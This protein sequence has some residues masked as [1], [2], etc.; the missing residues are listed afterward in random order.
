MKPDPKIETSDIFD[1]KQCGECCTGYGGT[2]V[3]DEDIKRISAFIDVDADRFVKEFC[4]LSA[5]KY[6]LAVGENG[7]CMFFN[8]KT[9]CTIHAVKPRM[10]RAWPF[11]EGVLRD[12]DN[13]EVMSGSCPGIRAD[14]STEDVVRCVKNELEKMKKS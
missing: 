13:W 5:G 6:V 9:Q 4:Q 2:Y 8:E 10:C 1:C 7:K 12:P 14:V 3:T 11:I